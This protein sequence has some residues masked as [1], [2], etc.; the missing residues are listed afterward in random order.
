MN[1]NKVKNR[2]S[3]YD[4]HGV[5]QFR[6]VQSTDPHKHTMKRNNFRRYIGTYNRKG[7]DLDNK[8]FGKDQSDKIK[9]AFRKGYKICVIGAYASDLNFLL[10]KNNGELVGNIIKHTKKSEFNCRRQIMCT[11]SK[12]SSKKITELWVLVF[13][14]KH[15]VDQI[16]QLIKAIVKDFSKK[17]TLSKKITTSVGVAH[18]SGIENSVSEWTEFRDFV[19]L[20]IRHGDVVIIGNVDLILPG[21]RDYSFIPTDEKFIEGGLDNMFGAKLLIHEHSYSRIVLIGSKESYWGDASAQYVKAILEAGAMHVLYGSKAA[22]VVKDGDI[23]KTYIPSHFILIDEDGENEDIHYYLNDISNIYKNLDIVRTGNAVTVPTVI[24]ESHEQLEKLDTDGIT[25]MDCEDGH[26][27]KVISEHNK[28]MSMPGPANLTSD[29]FKKTFFPV[30][31]ITDYIYNSREIINKKKSHLGDHANNNPKY[32]AR[33]DGQFRKIGNAFAAYGLMFGR[34]NLKN[35]FE[36]IFLNQST[37]EE[38]FETQYKKIRPLLDAGLGQQALSVLSSEQSG[39][40]KLGINKAIVQAIICQKEGYIDSALT[41]LEKFQDKQILDKLNDIEKCRVYVTSLKL[42]SQIGSINRMSGV[43]DILNLKENQI[44]LKDNNQFG[45]VKR[46]EAIYFAL[47]IKRE[48]SKDSIALAIA[49]EGIN[50]DEHYKNTNILFE[51]IT[52]LRFGNELSQ[53]KL[54]EISSKLSEVRKNYLSLGPHNNYWQTN[55]DK[56]AIA[57]LFLEASFY[58]S[59]SEDALI[60]KGAKILT[61]AHLFNSWFGGNE[62]SETYGEIVACT[63]DVRI[64]NIIALAMRTNTKSQFIFQRWI[65]TKFRNLTEIAKSFTEIYR[66]D[67][68]QRESEILKLINDN[69]L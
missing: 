63:P 37:T 33:R 18:F 24:G 60:K 55:L 17:V 6:D 40:E 3:L 47:Q 46:R 39:K 7:L 52:E 45:A 56:A 30:H 12:N 10:L 28:I 43:L 2:Q 68:K 25:C 64:K 13:P 31:F 57:A 69:N 29:D 58:L 49:G 35:K 16:A 1:K 67:S 20:F 22:S 36:N 9:E 32:K 54:E 62:I 44:I 5:L 38:D 11:V 15:Y 66:L 4:N 27:A 34:Q 41:I 61:I 19:S 50:P 8:K 53:T 14:S 65:N 42:Y 23:W 51:F 48:S 26:I 59:R 21:L